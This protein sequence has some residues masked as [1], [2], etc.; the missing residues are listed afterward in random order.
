MVARINDAVKV[1]SA[2]EY[3]EKKVAQNKAEV[4]EVKNFLQDRNRLTPGQKLERFNRLAELND[5]AEIKTLHISVN[6]DPK[7]QLSDETMTAI[8]DKYMEGIRLDQQPYIVYRHNDAGHPHMHIV[9]SLI[10]EDGKRIPTYN[11]GK[12][13]SSPARKAI[14]KEFNLIPARPQK[15]EVPEQTITPEPNTAPR[16]D[17]QKVGYG[18]GHDTRAETQRLLE[19]VNRDHTFT[20]LAEYNA[21]LRPY[22]LTADPGSEN[23]RTRK[24]GGL[25]YRALDEQGNKIGPTMKASS[26]PDKPTLATLQQKFTANQ[27]ARDQALPSLRRKID[28][29]Q[30]Q[31]PAT[32][33]EFTDEL[34]AEGVEL[35]VI[36]N[37]DNDKTDPTLIY[38][39]TRARAAVTDVTLGKNYTAGSLPER[40]P[41]A[42]DQSQQQARE[43]AKA[44]FQIPQPLSHLIP[45]HAPFGVS[46]KEFDQD[47]EQKKRHR[48]R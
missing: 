23:S 45:S 15:Q 43:I 9:V 18:P 3:N 42:Q 48:P 2:L 39:D 32:L 36:R 30:A 8:A 31:G 46:P 22:N 33:R 41:N 27:Q 6:F 35:T 19:A 7:E 28:W 1:S 38:T 20:T 11:I 17:L 4:L 29:V 25:L 26:F 37:K 47:Q 44:N 14:E 10:Q 40:I 21:L 34:R 24:H 13:L 5:R 12:N 16:Q